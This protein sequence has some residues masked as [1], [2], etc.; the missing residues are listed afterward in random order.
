MSSVVSVSLLAEV[1]ITLFV[2]M[3]PPGTVPIF[4]ALTSGSRRRHVD[5]RPGRRSWC[6]LW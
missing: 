1:F 3:D 6:R 5:A 4:L 2:I